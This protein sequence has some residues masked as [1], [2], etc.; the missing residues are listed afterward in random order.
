MASFPC[1]NYSN[2]PLKM[3]GHPL[4]VPE[5]KTETETPHNQVTMRTDANVANDNENMPSEG[6]PGGRK[7]RIE[8]STTKSSAVRKVAAKSSKAKLSKAKP[9]AIARKR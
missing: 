1:G 5:N 6:G 8:K 4:L 9:I 3:R 7:K 2:C